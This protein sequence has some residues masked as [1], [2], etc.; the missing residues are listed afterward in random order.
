MNILFLSTAHNSLSQRAYVE[1][2]DLGHNIYVQIA[3]SEQAM[4]DSVKLY[5]PDLIIAPFL[6]RY[7]PESIWSNYTCI[8]IHPGIIGDRGPSSLD[9]AV[10]NG[11]SEWGVTLLQANDMLDGGDIWASHNFTM[12]DV[13]KSHLYR[14]Q[15]TEAA[16]KCLLETIDRYESGNFNPKK[17][18]YNHNDVK[19]KEHRP[20][21]QKYRSIDWSE[22]T[23]VIAKKI[24]SADSQPGL[25]DSIY[26]ESF[27]LYG[28]HEE[29]TLKGN[30][31][32]IIGERNGALCR[33]TGDGAVWITHLKKKSQ[34]NH[35]Y[36][37]LPAAQVLGDKVNNIP[38]LPIEADVK[39]RTF[40]DIWY[41]ENNKVGY[42]HFNF[43]NGAMSTTQCIRLRDAFI[44]ARERDTNVIVLMGGSDFWSNGIHLNV[45]EGADNPADESWKNIN[46]INDLIK[47][48]ILT[49]THLIISAMRG[50]AAAGGVILALAADKV[51]AQNGVVLNP[52]Y[53]NMGLYGSEYWTYLLPKR[54]GMK[55]SIEL[56]D[57]CIPVSTKAAKKIGLIDDMFDGLNFKDKIIEIAEELALSPHYKSKL[58]EKQI[59]RIEDEKIKPLEFY[60][61]EELVK[62]FDNFYGSDKSYHIARK[63]FVYNIS[64]L[65]ELPKEVL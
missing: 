59:K 23:D 28:L 21:K 14:H 54:V 43:Y 18:D 15:V 61:K 9:W 65:D 41:E 6:K 12:K 63:R 58:K 3:S 45:I 57:Q 60:R 31:G 4:V 24:R 48:I 20:M 32:E 40:R 37:K 27:Y 35:K 50:N 44:K 62:M 25:L 49:D 33:A 1:L 26:G 19:G 2:T 29:D 5:N 52:H 38:H 46:A 16:I 42:L 64:C 13:S 34:G 36:F 17:L 8:I 51:F 53:K 39:G 10:L 56:T 11:E 7:I 55:K 30:P 47:E 22:A